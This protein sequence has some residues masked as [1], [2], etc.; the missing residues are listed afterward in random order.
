M[1]G[2][3]A[4]YLPVIGGGMAF[5]YK[6]YMVYLPEIARH[7]FLLFVHNPAGSTKLRDYSSGRSEVVGQP[8]IKWVLSRT[9]IGKTLFEYDPHKTTDVNYWRDE[10][11]KLNKRYPLNMAL[12]PSQ[13]AKNHARI[14]SGRASKGSRRQLQDYVNQEERVLSDAILETISPRVLELGGHIRWLSPLKSE[15]YREYRDNEFMTSVGCGHLCSELAS[16]WPALGPSWDALGVIHYSNNDI[17]PD[18]LLV[19]AKSHVKEVYGSGCHAVGASREKII[20]SLQAT[21]QWCGATD[22]ADWLG[23]LYQSA[24]RLAH[25]YF[26]LE[27]IKRPAWLVNVYFCGDPFCPTDR[28]QWEQEVEN[29]KI[30][31]GFKEPV[32]NLLSLFLPAFHDSTRKEIIGERRRPS[33]ESIGCR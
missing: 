11:E 20:R 10:T 26:L 28:E 17:L 31:L 7:S 3:T 13:A 23:P 15:D 4:W 1:L 19:E 30:Q 14:V 2:S 21:K 5:G 27:R 24:N 6:Y 16:F 25:L 12:A 9:T 22:A 8:E 29:L 32:K 18:I 33:D